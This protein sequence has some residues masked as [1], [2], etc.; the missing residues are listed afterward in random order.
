MRNRGLRAVWILVCGMAFLVGFAVMAAGC[1]WEVEYN[2]DMSS[3]DRLG[4]VPGYGC[5]SGYLDGGYD[6][7]MYYFDVNSSCTVRIETF[8]AGDTTLALLNNYGSQIAYDDDGGTGSASLISEYLTPGRYFAR[9]QAYGS[10]NFSYSVSVTCGGSSTTPT[11]P[12]GCDHEA[13]YNG[14]ISMADRLGSVPGYGCR[15]GYIDGGYDTDMYY[16]DVN[17]ACT[18]TVETFQ[19][20]D[21]TL[22]VLD[23][24]GNQV[25]YDDDSGVDRA[26]RI[27]QYM[28]PGRYY[29]RVEAYG[30]G[31]FSYGISVEHSGSTTTSPTP[32]TSCDR[33]VE[34]NGSA[35]SADYVAT[36]P[37]SGCRI[38]YIG[39]VYDEDYYWFEVLTQST[40]QIET[41]TSDDTQM[42]LLDSYG[43]Q[44]AYDDD[45]G[46]GLAS[47]ISIDLYP[48]TYAVR[49]MSYG[50]NAYFEYTLRVGSD[51]CPSEV[52]YN[53]TRGSADSLASLPGSGCRNGAID[54]AYDEDWY[55][56]VVRSQSYVV[57]ETE[58]SGDTYLQLYD[59]WGNL[60]ESDDDDGVGLGSRIGR[61]LTSGTYYVRVTHYSDGTVWQ[62]VLSA[63]TQ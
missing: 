37:G 17:S 59:Q 11:L 63:T 50:G 21:T 33:E 12:T 10:G 38:G 22:A 51:V 2:G 13:E 62:Y 15:S 61:S 39:D 23:S 47:F 27:T 4:S 28:V 20:G 18:V 41:V 30:S 53:D 49:V 54:H 58:T 25:A 56:I 32:T 35:G 48:G 14:E 29:A 44:I 42:W 46:D 1:D 8:D 24:Y 43:N 52:E 36:V 55:S 26:S 9:V 19:S 34:Y 45:D 16:F 6:T 40:V 31:N 57:L 5:R 60:I 3:S 7:D